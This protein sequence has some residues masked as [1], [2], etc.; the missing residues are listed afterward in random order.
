ML[1]SRR[2]VYSRTEWISD[3]TVH[4]LGVVLSLIA[5]PVLVTMTAILRPEVWPIL[6][7]SIYGATMIAMFLCSGLYN[8]IRAPEWCGT[9]KRMDH[10]AIYLKIAGTYT[11]FVML[12]GAAEIAL[13]L[14]LWIAAIAG[15]VLKVA[16]PNRFEWVGFTLY[17]AMGWIGVVA[18]WPLFATMTKP[19]LTLIV[20]GGLTYTL[21]TLFYL[22]H[23]MPFHR[24]IWHIFVVAG[25]AIFYAAVLTQVILTR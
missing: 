15:V 20:A 13:M 18:G 24:T 11:A 12:S 7:T 25:T 23:N 21:G 4:V 22:R 3:A 19:V 2:T 1:T 6:G 5:V 14:L 9:L 17:I 16:A 8:I 10:S